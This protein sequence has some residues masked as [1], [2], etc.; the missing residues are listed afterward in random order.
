MSAYK[1]KVDNMVW[2]YSRLSEFAQCRYAFYLKYLEGDADRV[3][4][5]NYYA[6]VGSFVHEILAKIFNGELTV[7]EAPEYFAEHF[8]DNVFYK[9]RKSI[10]DSTYEACANYFADVS[11]DWLKDFDIVGVEKKVDIEIGGEKF[12]GFIDLLLRD[13]ETGEYILIDHKSAAYPLSKSGTVLKSKQ[14]SYESYKKQMY[15][16][17]KAVHDLYGVY[18]TKIAWNHFKSLNWVEIPFI[19][20]D[21]DEAMQWFSDQI[22]EIKAEETF[23]ET[24]DFFYCHNLCDFRSSCEYVQFESGEE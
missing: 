21:F 12:I 9:T 11:F 5:G 13:K 20:E 10:M 19:K 23:P 14:K 8:D 3:A 17:C 22:N 24:M 6:E 18:P 1:D 15:L 16:Y 7:D 2:S 4:E